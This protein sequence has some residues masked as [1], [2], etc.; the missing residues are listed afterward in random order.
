MGKGPELMQQLPK[1][2]INLRPRLLQQWNIYGSNAKWCRLV[3]RASPE[4]WIVVEGKMSEPMGLAR[5]LNCSGDH[6]EKLEEQLST[7]L[8]GLLSHHYPVFKRFLCNS[9]SYTISRYFANTYEIHGSTIYL[10]MCD[11]WE[12]LMGLHWVEMFPPLSQFI[13]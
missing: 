12:S 11:S 6:R 2:Q 4:W 1:N 13:H 9:W 3:W 10:L 8:P 7:K 5:D